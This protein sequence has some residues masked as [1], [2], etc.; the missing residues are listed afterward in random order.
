MRQWWLE[1]S[2][3][4][5]LGQA[6]EEEQGSDQADPALRGWRGQPPGFCGEPLGELSNQVAWETGCWIQRIQK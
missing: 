3:G 2:W 4:Q 1:L 6:Q 5:S